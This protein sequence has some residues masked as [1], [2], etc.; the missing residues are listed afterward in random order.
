MATQ[1]LVNIGSGKS[2]LVRAIT[3]HLL[4]A[5]PLPEPMLIVNWTIRNKVHWNY[6][7]NSLKYF[8]SRKC[9]W[10]C[11]QNGS[12]FIHA[13]S[14]EGISV[15]CGWCLQWLLSEFKRKQYAPSW[16][17]KMVQ[18]Q[19]ELWTCSGLYYGPVFQQCQLNNCKMIITAWG[20]I[21]FVYHI[22]QFL[23]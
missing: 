21:V 20:V 15:A 7:Q 13:S 10:K 5:K 19:G 11:L 4:G 14:C 12:H 16:F 17:I 22:F 2:I 23:A 18:F 1:N 6:N 9:V 8:L 3:C